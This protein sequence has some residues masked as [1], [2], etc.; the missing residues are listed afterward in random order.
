VRPIVLITSNREKQLPEPFLR[1]CLYVQLDFPANDPAMLAEIVRKNLDARAETISDELIT[2][3]VERLCRIRERGRELGMQ[4]LPATSELV[5]WVRVLHWQ[6]RK[7]EAVSVDALDAV[8]QAVLF[9]I[10]QDIERYRARTD[11]EAG[12]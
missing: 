4:K 8:D 10:R 2:G 12:R 1:R 6:G 11:D 7:A 3:A 9:K 5:D